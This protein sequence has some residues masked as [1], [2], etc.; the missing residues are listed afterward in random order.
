[1]QSNAKS[2][3]ITEFSDIENVRTIPPFKPEQTLSWPLKIPPTRGGLKESLQAQ[4]RHEGV[5][6]ELAGSKATRR[7]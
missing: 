6:R 5:K 2:A 4:K 3:F 1:M 7:G